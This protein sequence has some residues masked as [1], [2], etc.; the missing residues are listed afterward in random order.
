M[1]TSYLDYYKLILEKVR[2]D[3]RLWKKEYQKALGILN[4]QEANE[5]RN[6]ALESNMLREP[7][8]KKEREK[9]ALY[10]RHRGYITRKLNSEK[11]VH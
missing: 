11:A 10:N 7:L 9:P 8:M 2:F 3:D 5:L 4:E 6:W 1:K